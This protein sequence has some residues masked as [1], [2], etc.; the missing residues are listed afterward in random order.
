MFHT[1]FV[2][3]RYFNLDPHPNDTST[4]P[5]TSKSHR[6]RSF[7]PQKLFPG[8]LLAVEKDHLQSVKESHRN[9]GTFNLLGLKNSPVK[10]KNRFFFCVN[11]SRG[12]QRRWTQKKWPSNLSI[13]CLIDPPSSR[14]SVSDMLSENV[15]PSG[16][17]TVGPGSA[18]RW[19]DSTNDAVKMLQLVV[20]PGR[21]GLSMRQWI[22][23][24]MQPIWP[25]G[26]CLGQNGHQ[27]IQ[28]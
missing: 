4:I 11:N 13:F 15:L 28:M 3:W 9:H 24:D 1:L 23:W 18:K 10:N 26:I 21:N 12:K 22:S 16:R 19:S 25:M 7:P 8:A 27:K 17:G 14:A 6:V 20:A 5:V 2:Y